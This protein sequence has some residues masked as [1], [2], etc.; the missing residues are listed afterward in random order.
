M[1]SLKPIKLNDGRSIPA[2]GF[3]TWRIGSGETVV[4][5][6]DQALSVGFDHIDTAQSYANQSEAGEAISLSG[7]SRS[8][9]WVTTKFSGYEFGLGI[10]EA[11]EDSLRKVS[12]E[13]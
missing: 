11:C 12:V 2:I 7:I 1:S 9:V 13:F 5:Q 4:T 6:V 3:G 8:D 10:Y